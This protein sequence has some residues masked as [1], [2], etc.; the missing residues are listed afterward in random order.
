MLHHRNATPVN[1]SRVVILGSS[2]FV[3]RALASEFSAQGVAHV[4]LASADLD[5]AKPETAAKL[6][7]ILK[8]D[9]ALVVLAALTPDKGRGIAPFQT[10]IAIMA[11]VVEAL[12]TV[13]PAHVVYF[14]SDA[15]YPFRQGLV[16][17]DTAAEPT[18]LYGAMH[19]TRELMIKE[20]VKGPVAVLRPTLIY[21]YEDTHNS[22]GPNRF[23][24]MAFKDGK[25]T[26]FGEGEETRDH[27]HVADVAKLTALA[28]RHRSHGLLN[29][30]TGSSVSYFDLAHKIK[31]LFGGKIEVIGTPRANPITHRHF[32]VTVRQQAFP[33][34]VPMALDDGLSRVHT[35]SLAAR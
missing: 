5:L 21:G 3:G 4:G 35:E 6:G 8:P 29:V 33:D 19:L 27:I 11:S 16:A 20:A 2:G 17:E 7:Q 13:Q 1:P 26:M 22:Y 34:F 12:K 24:R 28:L 9:D 15:V 31:G 10:N 18:D 14:S 32:D 25:I 30:A 23:R